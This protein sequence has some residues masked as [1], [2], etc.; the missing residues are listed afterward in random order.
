MIDSVDLSSSMASIIRN[1]KESLVIMKLSIGR[2][3][4]ILNVSIQMRSSIN[5]WYQRLKKENGN[6]IVRLGLLISQDKTASISSKLR[7]IPRSMR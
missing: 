3:Q 5:T 1:G 2:S 6:A 4:T 7:L